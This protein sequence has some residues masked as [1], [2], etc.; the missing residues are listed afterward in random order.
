MHVKQYLIRPGLV[1]RSLIKALSHQIYQVFEFEIVEK[2]YRPKNGI[3][4]RLTG[5]NSI[6]SDVWVNLEVNSNA[7]GPDRN[8]VNM[9]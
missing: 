7:N 8:M 3:S 5:T 2:T 1:F 4:M 9:Q 6:I